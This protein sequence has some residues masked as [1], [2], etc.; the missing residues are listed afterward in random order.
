[1]RES[2]LSTQTGTAIYL[3]KIVLPLARTRK[4]KSPRTFLDESTFY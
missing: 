2:I 1:M 4:L 3:D